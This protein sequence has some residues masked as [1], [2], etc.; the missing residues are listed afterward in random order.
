M[1][2]ASDH[3]GSRILSLLFGLAPFAFGAFRAVNARYDLRML[4]MALVSGAGAFTI[5]RMAERSDKHE[6]STRFAIL[7][8]VATT[9][10]GG[11]TAILLGATAAAGV[12]PV[13]VVLALCWTASYYFAQ[14]PSALPLT[15]PSP[16]ALK[17]PPEFLV[18]VFERGRDGHVRYSEGAHHYDFYWELCGAGCIVSVSIPSVT[19]WPRE[20]PWAVDRRDEVIARVGAAMSRDA[21]AGCTWR[22]N[23]DWLEVVEP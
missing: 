7:T 1:A 12:W 13:A 6:P 16:S 3:R 22:L 15:D 23:D 9:I 2:S 21:G 17:P 11:V 19:N 18:H 10:L 5:R 4:W 20:L 14:R 8:F